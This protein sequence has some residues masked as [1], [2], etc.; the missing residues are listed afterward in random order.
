M[1]HT[2]LYKGFVNKKISDTINGVNAAGTAA[3]GLITNK[4]SLLS[5]K[6]TSLIGF[7]TNLKQYVAAEAKDTVSGMWL[8]FSGCF[9]MALPRSCREAIAASAK[10]NDFAYF[11]RIHV[12][13]KRHDVGLG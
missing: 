4:G 8:N 10:T 9:C 7:I 5:G 6:S 13:L 3:Q 12:Q 2:A 11:A 1:A